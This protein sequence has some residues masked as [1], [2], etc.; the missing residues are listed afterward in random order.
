[1]Q[2]GE[3]KLVVQLASVGAKNQVYNVRDC[4]SGLA[5][6]LGEETDEEVDA[7]GRGGANTRRLPELKEISAGGKTLSTKSRI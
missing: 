1:M 5:E 6:W 7:V 3:K 2:L 4:L